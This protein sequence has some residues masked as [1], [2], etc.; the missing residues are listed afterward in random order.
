MK[1]TQLASRYAKSLFE[2]AIEQQC[3]NVV[4]DNML[5]L[6]SICKTNKDFRLMLSNPIIKIDKKQAIINA[7]FSKAFHAITLSFLNLIFKKR[8][9]ESIDKIAEEFVLLYK[10]KQNIKTAYLRSAVKLDESSKKLI[11]ERL[12]KQTN[13]T[14]EI[15]EEV[16]PSLI[17]GFVITIE[18]KQFDASVLKGINRLTKEFG[19]NIYLKK[20]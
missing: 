3:L 6:S 14:I 4:Y 12:A 18:D 8:R 9:E 1:G 7:L 17:G 15:I 16:D 13:A 10:R 20:I 2:F 19:T 5:E 11:T